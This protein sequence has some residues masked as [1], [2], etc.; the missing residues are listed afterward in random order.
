MLQPAKDL[1]VR[2]RPRGPSKPGCQQQG[3]VPPRT[4]GDLWTGNDCL[5]VRTLPGTAL[6]YSSAPLHPPRPQFPKP[7]P[8]VPPGQV[9]SRPLA[10]PPL[11]PKPQCFW[12]SQPHHSQGRPLWGPHPTSQLLPAGSQSSGKGSASPTHSRAVATLQ[13][14]LASDLGP[15]GSPPRAT[16]REPPRAT[17]QGTTPWGGE[18]SPAK[19]LPKNSLA[20]QCVPT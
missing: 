9:H 3:R 13:A 19:G 8:Q 4:Q 17:S 12:E 11:L 5:P 20:R 7:L 18:G 6:M 16:P 2:G 10:H 14:F 15:T 1:G